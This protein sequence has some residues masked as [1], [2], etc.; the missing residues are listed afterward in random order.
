MKKLIQIDASIVPPTHQSTENLMGCKKN[1]VTQVIEGRRNPGGIES[2]RGREIHATM[3]LYLSHCARKETSMDLEAFDT[4]S[5]GAGALA[6]KILVGVRDSY[7]VNYGSLFATELQ[8]RLDENFRP[9]NLSMELDG[10]CEDSGGETGYE[11]ILDGLFLYPDE[12]KIVI[13]DFKSHPRP[14]DPSDPNKSMQGKEYSVFCFLH[15]PWVQEVKFRLVFVRF[16]NLIKEVTYTREDVPSLIEAV[17]SLRNRQ[18]TIHQEYLSGVEI[19]ATGNDGCFYCPLLAGLE[20]P[21]A[22]ENPNAM[23]EP[24]EWLS[25]DNYYRAFATVNKARMKAYVQACGKPIILRDYVGKSY[26]Y[27]PVEKE[28]N[29]Y[30]L[31]ARNG[32]DIMTDPSGAPIMPIVGLLLTHREIAPED[33]DWLPNIVISSS[34]LESY[35][36]AKSRVITHQAIQDTAEK[37][38]K[39]TMKVS[40]PLD[41]LPPDDFEDED[42]DDGEFGEDTD[43]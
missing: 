10:V 23:M 41:V 42:G 34:K 37:V 27:G 35:L 16:R 14:Y 36:K 5:R 25:A 24:S 15:F 4:F 2:V 26:T 32:K 31:F 40:K 7:K 18:K 8:M 33:C 20:C 12:A 39:V 19:E 13:D 28:S 43:F 38:T 9:T 21:I 17:R 29:S 1:Y 6:S 22:K 3:A 30:P 11:G